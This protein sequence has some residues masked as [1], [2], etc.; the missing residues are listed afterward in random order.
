MHYDNL[1]IMRIHLGI[2]TW[3]GDWL[4]P[5]QYD[6]L[7][8]TTICIMRISTV[9]PYIVRKLKGEDWHK[10]CNLLPRVRLAGSRP[11]VRQLICNKLLFS[12]NIEITAWGNGAARRPLAFFYM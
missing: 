7:R 8:L 6:N 9:F 3:V 2:K 1:C 4:N 12:F 11:Y 10:I 5:M